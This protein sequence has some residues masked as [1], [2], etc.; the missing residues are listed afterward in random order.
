[1]STA[2]AEK[3]VDVVNEM[4]GLT[5]RIAGMTLLG[6]DPAGHAQEVGRAVD[7]V[8]R[9]VDYLI[10]TPIRPPAWVPTRRH[11][12]ARWC[13]RT[14]DRV[15]G[16]IIRQRRSADEPGDDLL[17]MLM[18]AQ[19]EDTGEKMTDRQLRDE[20]LTI[21][22]AGHETTSNALSWTFYLLSRHPEV[23][24]RCRAEVREVL[25]GRRPE[26]DD[27]RSLEYLDR[28][29]KE[30][31]R[32]YPPA[33]FF[34]RNVCQDDV[35]GGKRIEKGAIIGVAPWVTHRLEHLWPDPTRF[36]PDRFLPEAS[37]GRP[38]FAYFP[39]GGGQRL[40]IGKAFATMESV[41]IAARIL[42]RYDLRLVPGFPVEPD[43]LV[44]LRPKHGLQMVPVPHEGC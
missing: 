33:W 4:M 23:L 42:Q 11:R 20:V 39:F 41:L 2:R 8:N 3:P 25:G 21:F 18:E 7:I 38:R 40:C 5:Q 29:V 44:T 19:D 15:V 34:E 36:D 28:V 30:S 35:I 13:V 27:L 32:L 10:M 31:L 16:D 6:M 24:E 9:H 1:M 37:K 14:L 12:E 26:A 43:P 17:A 22:V